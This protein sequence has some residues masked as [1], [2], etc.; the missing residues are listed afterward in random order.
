[1]NEVKTNSTFLIFFLLA[2]LIALLSLAFI[3][4][5]NNRVRIDNLKHE[6][7]AANPANPF[8]GIELAARA[9]IVFD[10]REGKV[11]FSKNSE[12]VLPLASLAKVM[13]ALTAVELV[14]DYTTV[15][16][17]R[18]YLLEEGDVGFL[19][20]E[21]W[22]LGDLLAASLISSSN[23]G[24]RAVAAAAAASISAGDTE[25]AHKLF[26]SEM[27]KKAV[28]IGLSK[29]YFE[30][31][32]GLDKNNDISGAYGSARDIAELFGYALENHGDI[33]EP[34]KYEELTFISLSNIKHYMK[35]TN[36]ALNSLPGLI[37]SK[38]G[39]TDL[40]GG[41]LAVVVDVGLEGPYVISV[42]GSTYDGR[43][44]DVEKLSDAL[45]EYVVKVK[46]PQVSIIKQ[47]DN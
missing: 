44:T 11:I 38:T 28:E 47:N 37:A 40:A 10:M 34:T 33:F 32:N 25:T 5:K 23:D 16:M 42:L 19:A 1:M 14:P 18:E 7:A 41:N 35:N 24:M 21:K 15:T 4:N 43:F 13:A 17:T 22:K 39:F 8:E 36:P 20:D 3:Y 46:G 29:A 6:I 26:V 27:N 2:A 45:G 9:A 30:N 12:E 31:E